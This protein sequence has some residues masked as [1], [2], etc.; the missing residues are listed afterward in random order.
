[1]SPIRLFNILSELDAKTESETSLFKAVFYETCFCVLALI[2]FLIFLSIYLSSSF[3][4]VWMLQ[5]FMN[6]DYPII[7]HLGY[8]LIWICAF[9]LFFQDNK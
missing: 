4:M 5:K 1:M 2:T 7:F 9:I 8:L 6:C 3:I